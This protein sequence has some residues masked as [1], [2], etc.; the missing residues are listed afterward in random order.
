MYFVEVFLKIH[1]NCTID[2]N[3]IFTLSVKTY[4]NALILSSKHIF[5]G[6]KG[7]CFFKSRYFF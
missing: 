4:I 3:Q 6:Q 5:L 1:I 2:Y 7:N